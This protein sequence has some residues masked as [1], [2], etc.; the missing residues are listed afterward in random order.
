MTNPYATAGHIRA[1]LLGIRDNYEAALAG[2]APRD[3][4]DARPARAEAPPPV[5]PHI[6]DVRAAVHHDLA[7]F[8]LF[9][10]EQVNHGTITTRVDGHSVE[11]L[12][13]FIDTWAQA[14]AEQHPDDAEQCRRDMAHHA[15]P[16]PSR[17]GTYE[18]SSTSSPKP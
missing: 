3:D 1:A 12:C 5:S 17:S 10:F 15:A 13:R 4:S 11:A 6:L 8:A 18:P 16:R 14:L 9:I 2:T 7:V